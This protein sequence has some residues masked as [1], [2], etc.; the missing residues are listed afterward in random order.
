MDA[1]LASLDAIFDKQKTAS[2]AEGRRVEFFE[3]K[4]KQK[5]GTWKKTGHLY[6]QYRWKADTGRKSK[7]GGRL[8]TVPNLYRKRADQYQASIGNRGA[9]SLADALFRPAV[10]GLSHGDTG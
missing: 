5:D 4:R 3:G 7:Y 1:I 6:W 2:I 10:S 8:E 9:E